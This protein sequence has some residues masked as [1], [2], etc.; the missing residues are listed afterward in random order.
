MK[1]VLESMKGS[2][3]PKNRSIDVDTME[4]MLKETFVRTASNPKELKY[5][6]ACIL[7]Q[8]SLF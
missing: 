8:N 3:E 2:T 7:Y 6:F 4:E 5:H 1:D